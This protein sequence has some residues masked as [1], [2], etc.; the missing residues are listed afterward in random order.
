MAKKNF[1]NAVT[2]LL[3]G[4]QQTEAPKQVK[5]DARTRS[6]AALAASVDKSTIG[7]ET[8]SIGVNTTFYAKIKEIAYRENLTIKKV[9][10]KAIESAINTYEAK[11]GT[12]KLPKIKQGDENEIF[13]F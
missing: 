5:R 4:Q 8:I 12:I 11:N 10:E 3:G 2:D 1:D 13:A 6:R 9:M 7:Y